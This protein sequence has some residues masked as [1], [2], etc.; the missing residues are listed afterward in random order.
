[1]VA[2]LTAAVLLPL[3]LAGCGPQT[4]DAAVQNF[5]KV[6]QNHDWNGYLSSILPS[7]VR[8]ATDADLVSQ[9]KTFMGNDYKYTALKLKTVPDKKDPSKASVQLTSGVVTGKNP[10]TGQTE[11][12]TIAQ[13]KKQYGVTPTLQA[14]KYKGRWYVDVPLATADQPVQQQ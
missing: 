6:I 1:M 8:R 3:L 5:Y 11:S 7:N 2:V 14:L 12:T 9:K 4:P 10:Q 13:I